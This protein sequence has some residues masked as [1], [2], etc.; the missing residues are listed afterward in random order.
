MRPSIASAVLF[1]LAVTA[2]A[3]TIPIPSPLS[4]TIAILA[5]RHFPHINPVEAITT[6]ATLAVPGAG[7]VKGAE[8]LGKVAMHEAREHG[9]DIVG[10][11]L[12]HHHP[13]Q[14]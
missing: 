6:V 10:N 13:T 2:P 11:L 3:L 9:G 12:G 5:K 14:N 1:F 4:D 7:E 8:L